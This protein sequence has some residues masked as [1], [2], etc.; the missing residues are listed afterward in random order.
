MIKR[1]KILISIAAVSFL[2]AGCSGS[3]ATAGS[4]SPAAPVSPVAAF[5][6]LS[7]QVRS[8]LTAAVRGPGSAAACTKLSQGSLGGWVKQLRTEPDTVAGPLDAYLVRVQ[9]ALDAC[10]DA[11]YTPADLSQVDQSA[12]AVHAALAPAPSPTATPSTSSSPT[13]ASGT[14]LLFYGAADLVQPRPVAADTS[15]APAAPALDAPGANPA[16]TS[17]CPADFAAAGNGEPGLAFVNAVD[18][19]STAGETTESLS[20][21]FAADAEVRAMVPCNAAQRA[22]QEAT[23]D[24][25][26]WMTAGEACR[27]AYYYPARTLSDVDLWLDCIGPVN[28]AVVSQEETANNLLIAAENTPCTGGYTPGPLPMTTGLAYA[29][30]VQVAGV[31]TEA[32]QAVKS[33]TE[34]TEIGRDG[35]ELLGDRELTG[36]EATALRTKLA[37][38]LNGQ[39]VEVTGDVLYDTLDT[40]SLSPSPSPAKSDTGDGETPNFA[41]TVT[42]SGPGLAP[43]SAS[44]SA[45]VSSS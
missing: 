16:R 33:A 29:H 10:R 14:A 24:F 43:Q 42:I 15:A 7:Q 11:S 44:T 2:A 8:Q 32:F 4:S 31:L 27:E 36:Q 25:L 40:F 22:Y 18:K 28:A 6:E 41:A 39:A 21:A 1:A 12:S 20:V 34:V 37:V 3:G 30:V 19:A 35:L 9:L 5:T 17:F 38:E 45:S 26:D 23:L 13:S